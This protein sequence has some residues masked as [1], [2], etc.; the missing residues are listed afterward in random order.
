MSLS[1]EGAKVFLDNGDDIILRIDFGMHRGTNPLHLKI[2]IR[3]ES[4]DEDTIDQRLNDLTRGH[5]WELSK[6]VNGSIKLL[7]IL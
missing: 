5:D 6:Y 1:I 2:L 7:E 4:Y 3:A